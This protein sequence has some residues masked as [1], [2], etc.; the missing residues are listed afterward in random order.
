MSLPRSLRLVSGI[1]GVALFFP[2][3]ILAQQEEATDAAPVTQEPAAWVRVWLMSDGPAGQVDVVA[4]STKTGEE[5][6]GLLSGAPPWF[7]TG[8]RDIEPGNTTVNLLKRDAARTVVAR[9][10]HRF[11]KGHYYTLL[12]TSEGQASNVEVIEDTVDEKITPKPEETAVEESEIESEPGNVQTR[13]VVPRRIM[14]YHFLPNLDIEVA[15][16][17]VQFSG[18]LAFK[19]RAVIN[20]P[21]AQ[22][23]VLFVKP[24]LKD[25]VVEPA[26]IDF[27]TT[28]NPSVS[29][30]VI[31]DVY[32][33]FSPRLVANGALD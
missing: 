22:D 8:Y 25:V 13:P 32:G 9:L 2:F 4:E 30:L 1:L 20:E 17:A 23:I 5:P 14:I 6:I 26:E 21:A 16:P 27:S 33:R 15:A 18:S 12:I 28:Q 19:Q 24:V 29:L 3:V 7:Y 10:T 11:R 31:Q